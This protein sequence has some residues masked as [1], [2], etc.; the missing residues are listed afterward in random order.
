MRVV[1]DIAHKVDS[2]ALHREYLVIAFHRQF[3]LRVQIVVYEHADTVQS[4]FVASK[5]HYVVGITVIIPHPGHFFY[6]V[7]KFRQIEV[8]EVL[9]NIV[10]YGNTRSTGNNA[11]KQPKH[12][13]VLDFTA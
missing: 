7:V 8:S 2:P 9:G 11:V 3:A 5:H 4:G 12:C 13:R 1:G 6:E 10:A